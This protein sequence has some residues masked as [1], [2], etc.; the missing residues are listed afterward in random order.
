MKKWR[1]ESDIEGVGGTIEAARYTSVEVEGNLG[2][3]FYVDDSENMAVWF[4]G[5][6]VL[7]LLE[8]D[9]ERPSKANGSGA[10]KPRSSTF[11]A[12]AA[13]AKSGDI[14]YTPEQVK[15]LLLEKIGETPRKRIAGEMD[16]NASHLGQALNGQIRASAKMIKWAG[17]EPIDRRHTRTA[18]SE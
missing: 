14:E 4:S 5:P 16:V 2:I 11:D 13:I 1:V 12:N 7:E 10:R 15:A 3:G 9:D 6:R 8:S 18:V 17:L